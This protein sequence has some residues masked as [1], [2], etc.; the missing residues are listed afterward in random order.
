[1]VIS[2]SSKERRDG[3]SV[4]SA[5]TVAKNRHG[6]AREIPVRW[7]FRTFRVT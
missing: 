2:G 5:V 4:E 3:L 1:V 6:P 7:D